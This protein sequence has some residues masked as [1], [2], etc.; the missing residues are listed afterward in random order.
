MH[1]LNIHKVNQESSIS[2][3]SQNTNQLR[4]KDG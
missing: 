1:D 4:M 3:Q 2:F